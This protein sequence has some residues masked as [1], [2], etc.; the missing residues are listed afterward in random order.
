M[1][2]KSK[3]FKFLKIFFPSKRPKTPWNLFTTPFVQPRINFRPVF[4]KKE[5][6][7]FSRN[8]WPRICKKSQKTGY[9]RKKFFSLETTQNALKF[10]RNTIYAVHDK[11]PVSIS[12]KRRWSF[13]MKSVTPDMQKKLKNFKF[14]EKNFF[15]RNNLKCLKICS[16]HNLC[17]PRQISGRYFSKK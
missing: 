11:F 15:A 9:L 2:K 7:H 17:S 3:N 6:G 16:Q 10:V 8:L 1:Q 12:Q 14:L 4:L 13:F 5:V